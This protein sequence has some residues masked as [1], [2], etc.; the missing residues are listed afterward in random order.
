MSVEN[1]VELSKSRAAWKRAVDAVVN[2]NDAAKANQIIESSYK[3]PCARRSAATH[4]RRALTKQN[5]DPRSIKTSPDDVRACKR[6]TCEHGTCEY[7]TWQA[8]H[9]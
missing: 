2:T 4:V 9:V 8:E 6:S 1:G 7:G 5:K 3:T